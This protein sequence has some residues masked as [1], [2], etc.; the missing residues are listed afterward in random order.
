MPLFC[1][2]AGGSLLPGEALAIDNSVRIGTGVWCLWGSGMG[3]EDHGAGGCYPS[4]RTGLA[5]TTIPETQTEDSNLCHRRRNELEG[6]RTWLTQGQR[7][8]VSTGGEQEQVIEADTLTPSLL[9]LTG[10][11]AALWKLGLTQERGPCSGEGS[12]KGN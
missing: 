6:Q 11:P 5:S 7:R 4:T 2:P 1:V 12:G 8:K 10:S 3:P 9:S